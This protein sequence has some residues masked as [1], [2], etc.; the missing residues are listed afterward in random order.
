MIDYTAR[1]DGL[2]R[3]TITIKTDEL[4]TFYDLQ[5]TIDGIKSNSTPTSPKATKEQVAQPKTRSK[6]E[7]KKFDKK[8]EIKLVFSINRD[9]KD[10]NVKK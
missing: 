6:N 8:I 7:K 4:L 9:K 1:A 5:H 10:K 2:K 3:F